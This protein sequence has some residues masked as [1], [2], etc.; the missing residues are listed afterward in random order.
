MNRDAEIADIMLIGHLG[1]TLIA[2][3]GVYLGISLD[4]IINKLGN[5]WYSYVAEIVLLV[6]GA[7]LLLYAKMRLAKL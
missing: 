1:L 2:L 6:L 7:A 4:S 5:P 3:S